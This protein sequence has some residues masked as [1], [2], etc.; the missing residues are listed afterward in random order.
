LTDFARR[1]QNELYNAWDVDAWGVWAIERRD[2]YG[3]LPSDARY[4]DWAPLDYMHLVPVSRHHIAE[5]MMLA[6]EW[7][8]T[9]DAVLDLPISTYRERIAIRHARTMHQPLWMPLGL[10]EHA[11][12]AE[13][14]PRMKAPSPNNVRR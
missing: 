9:P 8:M 11:Y 13:H 1:T 4:S 2:R 14:T 10:G 3:F 7:N 12:H 6:S 5:A